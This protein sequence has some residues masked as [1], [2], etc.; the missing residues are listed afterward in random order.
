M[1]NIRDT[2]S[3]QKEFYINYIISF[4]LIF[5]Q[6]KEYEIHLQPTPPPPSKKNITKNPKKQTK[7]KCKWAKPVLDWKSIHGIIHVHF[8]P[9]TD[10]ATCV[11]MHIYY[12]RPPEGGRLHDMKVVSGYVFLRTYYVSKNKIK[13]KCIMIC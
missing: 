4:A 13:I 7:I 3:L 6:Y 2:L 1:K 10:P 8:G 12:Y 9:K 5:F 11:G